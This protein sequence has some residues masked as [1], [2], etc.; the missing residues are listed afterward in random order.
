MMSG[1]DTSVWSYVSEEFRPH[2]Y[3]SELGY[4]L[5]CP[6]YRQSELM[7]CLRFGRKD[8]DI[9]NAGAKVNRKWGAWAGPWA[10]TVHR[11]SDVLDDLPSSYR[12]SKMRREIPIMCGMTRTE[13][14]QYL[15]NCMFDF[16]YNRFFV[17][18][19]VTQILLISMASMYR[20]KLS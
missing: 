7:E 5:G 4:E 1:A 15:R 13:G 11:Q 10:I 8:L 3:A 2:E 14:A 19:S 6:Y 9:A 18:F 16:L 12:A 17:Y 20:Q